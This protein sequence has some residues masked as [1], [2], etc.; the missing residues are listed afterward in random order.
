[1]RRDYANLKND[2]NGY[3]GYDNW[4]ARDLNNAQ[5]STVTTYYN[6]V[7]AIEKILEEN[8]YELSSFYNAIAALT[9]MSLE[10]REYLLSSKIN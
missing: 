3:D 2:W 8:N 7:P 4:M 10:Q 6:W 5:L 9:D 1:M